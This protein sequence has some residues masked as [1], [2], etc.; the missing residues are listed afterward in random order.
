MSLTEI[1][2]MKLFVCVGYGN[3]VL[4]FTRLKEEFTQKFLLN[5]KSHMTD[6]CEEQI[7][8]ALKCYFVSVLMSLS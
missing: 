7:Y 8:I 4:I 5:Y 2:F 6:L 1:V 3:G